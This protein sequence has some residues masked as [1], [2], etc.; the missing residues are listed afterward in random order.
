MIAMENEEGMLAVV[1]VVGVGMTMPVL[2]LRLCKFTPI[3]AEFHLA[4]DAF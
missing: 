4:G 1:W 2:V 3:C